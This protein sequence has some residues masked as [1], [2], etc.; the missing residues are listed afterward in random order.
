MAAIGAG[1]LFFI[2]DLIADGNSILHAEVYRIILFTEVQPNASKQIGWCFTLQQDNDPKLAAKATKGLSG[3]RSEI[4]ST[5]QI[6]H[7]TWIQLNCEDTLW[8]QN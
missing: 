1:L 3:P 4:Y 6:N 8:R 2:D 5:N 7:P